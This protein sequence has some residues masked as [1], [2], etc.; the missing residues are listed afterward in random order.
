MPFRIM[1]DLKGMP[2]A[3][4]CPNISEND[5]NWKPASEGCN[6]VTSGEREPSG[7]GPWEG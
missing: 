7:T 4:I 1:Q 5:E 3:R 2:A 6:E